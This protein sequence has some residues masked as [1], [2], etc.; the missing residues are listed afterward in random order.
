MTDS[1][2]KEQVS[3]SSNSS[4]DE[5]KGASELKN[6]IEAAIFAAHEPIG[7]RK[8]QAIFM[9]GAQP[10]K[11]EIDA[12]V[13]EL[14]SDYEHTGLELAR[15]GAGWRFQTREKYSSWMR[16]LSADKAPRYSRAQ[17]ETL[18]IIAYRQPVTRGDIEEVRGVSVS[19][20]IIR[21]LEERGWIREIGHRDVP[22]RP[23]LFG[24]TQEFLSYFNLRSLKE[25]P[26][27]IEKRKFEEI[28]QEMHMQLPLEA[29]EDNADKVEE[30]G[31]T[32]LNSAEIIPLHQDST[33]EALVDDSVET[34]TDESVDVS[35]DDFSQTTADDPSKTN[36]DDSINEE[37]DSQ[38][39]DNEPDNSEST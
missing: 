10:S 14:E 18:S 38:N 20:D 9:D 27:L 34:N 16:R 37:N 39:Q 17:L 7:V 21:I 5:G 4:S 13:D 29:P 2:N 6:I 36:V 8:L 26:E 33:T 23:A 30:K 24:T 12:I 32:E 3:D 11:E 1:K 15:I 19:S 25:L 22:G 28:A 31:E 35:V